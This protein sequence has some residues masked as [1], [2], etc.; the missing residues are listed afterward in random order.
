MS[1]SSRYRPGY[2]L[3]ARGSRGFTILELVVV[4]L[5]GMVLAAIAIPVVQST[6]RVLA[7]R[8]AVASITGAISSTRYQ[9]I[10]SG[11]KSQIAFTKA[12]YS[13]QVSSQAAALN[14]QTCLAAYANV[15]GVVPVQ[16][17]GTALGADITLTFSPGGGVT[18]APAANP[19][20]MNLTLPGTS[21]PAE[22]IK[23]SNYGNITVTP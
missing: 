19:I 13:Y 10:F 21:L 2:R 11:C 1:S 7:M 22:Q 6:L 14:G 16:G 12:S 3:Q 17:R 4:V 9:A 23:V 15:G 18:A 8:S 20:L 5:V